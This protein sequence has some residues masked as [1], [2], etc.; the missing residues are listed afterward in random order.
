[1]STQGDADA[2]PLDAVVNLL[3]TPENPPRDIDGMD[4]ERCIALHNAIFLHGWISSG[5]AAEDFDAQS[6]TWFGFYGEGDSERFHPS[7]RAF[8]HEARVVLYDYNAPKFSFHVLGLQCPADLGMWI[9]SPD[10]WDEEDS[11][12]ILTLYATYPTFASKYDGLVYDQHTHRA[13][14]HFDITDDLLL[15]PEQPWQKLESVLSVWIEMIQREKVVALHDDVDRD[16]GWPHDAERDLAMKLNRHYRLEG[17]QT[18][19]TMAPWSAIDLEQTLEVWQMAVEMI[20]QKMGLNDDGSTQDITSNNSKPDDGLIHAVA[21]DLAEIPDGFAHKFLR[22]ARRPRFT[23]IAPGLRCPSVEDIA[24]Q[25]FIE[26]RQQNSEDLT[27]PEPEKVSPILLFRSDAT[28]SSTEGMN[29]WYQGPYAQTRDFP[30]GLYLDPCNRG[31]DMPFEDGCRLI[32]PFEFD[33][34][35]AGWAKQSDGSRAEGR[36]NLYQSGKNPYNYPHAVQLQAFLE[37]VYLNVRSG[38][39]NVDAHGVAGGVEKWK[40]ADS[41]DHWAQ[42]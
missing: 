30:S 33:L 34:F 9:N 25:P 40:E 12:R 1:M 29:G 19:W 38:Y 26:S 22:R 16:Q 5:R 42:Y 17:E 21:L 24:I 14:I 27:H 41:Q 18:P 13:I 10:R 36:D 20:E 35:E 37:N 11:D 28:V 4:S 6:Q 8:L 2:S 39:W 7:L 3:V 15:Y 23:F 32:L 31:H